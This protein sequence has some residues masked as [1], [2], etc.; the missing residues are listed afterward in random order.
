ML[1]NSELSHARQ[2]PI[3]IPTVYRNN[4]LAALRAASHNDD[5]DSLMAALRFA[6]RYT[7]RIDF[8]TRASAEADLAQ[9]NAL[10]QPVVA[11][12]AGIGPQMPK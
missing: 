9:T 2:A 8:S 12:A 11:N 4:Y 7:A 5:L 1:L 10:R 6:Q 3:I